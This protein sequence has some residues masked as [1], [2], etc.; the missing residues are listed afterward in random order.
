MCALPAE[1]GGPI[2]RLA[3][4]RHDPLGET[5]ANE[6]V[7]GADQSGRLETGWIDVGACLEPAIAGHLCRRDEPS[8][9]TGGLDE[10]SQHLAV[11]VAR[12]D[13]VR[14]VRGHAPIIARPVIAD[15]TPSDRSPMYESTR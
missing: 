5:E 8:F 14:I 9:V 4:G 1:L 11:V 12:S 10:S 6:I 15:T 3:R 2:R 13:V 7:E